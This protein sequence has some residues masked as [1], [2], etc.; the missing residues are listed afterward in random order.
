MRHIRRDLTDRSEKRS[1]YRNSKRYSRSGDQMMVV[2]VTG[3][4]VLAELDKIN[5]GIILSL[6]YVAERFPKQRLIILSSLAEGADR[7]VAYLGLA[8]PNSRLIALLPLSKDDYLIDFKSPESREEFLS[9]LAKAEKVIEMPSVSSRDEAYEA[10]GV[11]LLNH[12]DV[13]IAVWDGKNS[14]GRGGT[15]EIVEL[16]RSRRMPIAWV[17]AGNRRPGTHQ[18]SSLGPRQGDVTFENF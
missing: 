4:R 2:G 18:P 12:S 10:A 9:L 15:A 1:S 6:D 11:Y 3:H 7:L 5:E 8:R 17:Q 16:A 14:Q 13:L